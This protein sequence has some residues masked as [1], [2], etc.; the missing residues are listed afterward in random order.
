MGGIGSGGFVAD[1]IESGFV[2][3]GSRSL[4]MRTDLLGGTG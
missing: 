4:S 3:V 1:I 2:V